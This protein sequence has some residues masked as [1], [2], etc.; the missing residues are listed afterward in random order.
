LQ[1]HPSPE[2][3]GARFLE[4]D[5]KKPR[6]VRGFLDFA[7]G[8]YLARPEP[9]PVGVNVDP[10]G[11]ALGES[12]LPDGFIGVG[13]TDELLFIEP[14]A[15]PTVPLVVPGADV[16]PVPLIAAPPLVAAPAPAPPVPC[17]KASVLDSANAP[18]NP[19][20]V[21]FMVVSFGCGSKSTGGNHLC[22]DHFSL[23]NAAWKHP[24]TVMMERI[25]ISPA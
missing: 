6:D 24:D 10:L 4:A 17:A 2:E 7:A 8:F 23:T 21:S 9:G 12:V 19:I 1:P 16:V 11:D 14:G 3:T 25:T 5:N 20:V 15:L 18:A 13:E 22:S